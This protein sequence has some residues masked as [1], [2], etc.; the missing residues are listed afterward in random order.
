MAEQAAFTDAPLPTFT[1]A[2]LV[3][4][5]PTDAALAR[6]QADQHGTAYLGQTL[7]NVPKDVLQQAEGAL[8]L[9]KTVVGAG[10]ELGASF[11]SR[12]REIFGAE[13]YYPQGTPNIDE[14]QKAPGAI[15]QH[16]ADYADP[17]KRAL[18]V[19]EHPVGLALDVA[20]A[21]A[22][23][24]KGAAGTSAAA[25]RVASAVSN[26]TVRT[27]AGIAA[28]HIPIVSSARKFSRTVDAFN[29]L[30]QQIGASRTAADA[31]A[32]SSAAP[33]AA[34]PDVPV[35][36]DV[37]ATPPR[38][39]TPRTAP[40]QGAS[41][42]AS[43]SDASLTLEPAERTKGQM[44]P[45]WI[46]NDL[47]LAAR[48]QKLTMTPEQFSQAEAMVRDGHSPMDAVKLI[49]TGESPVLAASLNPS[50]V[51]EYAR[52][53]RSGRTPA[54]AGQAIAVQ[55]QL[56]QGRGLPSTE[57]VIGKVVDR[58]TTGRWTK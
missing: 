36:V 23:A 25:S 12:V 48:R 49:G 3:R 2:P 4:P 51:Q 1:D 47:G 22:G 42:K 40:P 52:L 44:S 10:G 43:E 33:V 54:E 57:D 26:P 46:Q 58:N 38:A 24:S 16:F 7:A 55:R 11:G 27:L 35:S 19:R 9:L 29:Q 34:V 8:H 13:P 56:L 50:E 53:I 14:L 30:A 18:M 39:Q 37:P 45:A 28:D 32:A 31:P 41:V 21:K 17:E 6:Q 5:Q 20:G 15:V